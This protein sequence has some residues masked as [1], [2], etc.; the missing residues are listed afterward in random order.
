[1]FESVIQQDVSVFYLL[2]SSLNTLTY[3]HTHTH[4]SVAET[5]TETPYLP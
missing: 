4:S 1:M 2:T 5:P 3:A